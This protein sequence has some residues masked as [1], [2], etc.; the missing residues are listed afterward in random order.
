MINAP[1]VTF[2]T[3]TPPRLMPILGALSAACRNGIAERWSRVVSY[4]V[5]VHSTEFEVHS[6]A[7]VVGSAAFVSTIAQRHPK[8]KGLVGGGYY[9][10]AV[11]YSVLPGGV[12]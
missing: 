3:L 5:T 12:F 2:V 10:D 11:S 4:T 6:T 7:I 9:V 1:P 8:K